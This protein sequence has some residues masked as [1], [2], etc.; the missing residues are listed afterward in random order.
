MWHCCTNEMQLLIHINNNV[1]CVLDHFE[2]Q[3][4]QVHRA[5]IRETA[6]QIINTRARHSAVYNTQYNTATHLTL[7]EMRETSQHIT[8]T[9]KQQSTV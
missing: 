5:K 7:P 3:N 2:Y 4:K 1:R 9:R 6:P 8:N